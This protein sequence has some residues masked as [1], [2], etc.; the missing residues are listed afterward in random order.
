MIEFTSGKTIWT[1][2]MILTY[3]FALMGIQASPAFTMWQF[4]NK[5]P[6]PFPWQQAFAS[7]FVVGF[8]LFF[9]TAFQGL[10]GVLLTDVLGITKDSD[11]VPL[12]MKN[13][14]PGFWLGLVFIGAIAA[15]HSTAAPYVGTG[16]TIIC[17][18]VY[19]LSLI[20]I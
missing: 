14:I 3:M 8:A 20:H 17:R 4:G 16:A 9:F 11:L 19:F 2:V 18:D 1:G 5:N 12:L 10:G 13:Y 6:R 7:T 15:M